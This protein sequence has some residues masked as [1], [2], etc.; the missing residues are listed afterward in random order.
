MALSA[1]SGDRALLS[2][3][4]GYPYDIPESCYVLA[5]GRAL[6]L[7]GVDLS[8]ASGCQVLDDGT[9]HSLREWAERRG[10]PGSGESTSELLA[11]GSNASIDGLSTLR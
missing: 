6:S 2:R 1:D 10:I 8:C 7:V 5:G 9:A 3:A 11:Y 4:K